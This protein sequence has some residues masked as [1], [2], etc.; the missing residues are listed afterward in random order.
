MEVATIAPVPTKAAD[1]DLELIERYRL[2]DPSAFDEIFERYQRMVFNLALR[3][4]GDAERAADLSQE[5]FLRVYRHVG[6]FKGQSSLKTWIYRVSVNCCRSR[7]ARRRLPIQSPAD[8]GIDLLE[9]VRDTGAGPERQA[10]AR[11][12]LGQVMAALRE[13][14]A[15]YR[16]AVVLRDVEELTY[17]EISE[18]LDV[19]LG[20]VRSRIARGRDR[21]RQLL[22]EGE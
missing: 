2:G 5:I 11:E 10:I 20:T 8:P 9:R 3:L 16:E 4:S 17:E 1:P 18:V 6:R 15:P 13:L 7:L 22:E 14:P 21:L 19:R 12:R